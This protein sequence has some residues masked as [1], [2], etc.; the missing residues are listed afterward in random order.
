MCQLC[1]AATVGAYTSMTHA[2]R[3]IVAE[4]GV[5]ALYKGWVPSVIG[6]PLV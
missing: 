2:A 6:V 5:G 4:E 1:A 3:V